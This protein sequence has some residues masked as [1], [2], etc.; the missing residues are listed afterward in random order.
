MGLMMGIRCK[1]DWA[2]KVFDEA[3]T[4]KWREEAQRQ[5]LT[6]IE[7]QYAIDECQWWAKQALKEAQISAVEGVFLADNVVSDDLRL[8]LSSGLKRLEN[9]PNDQKDWHPRSDNQVLDLIHPSLFP[10]VYGRSR[11]VPGDQ[12][13]SYQELMNASE[14]QVIPAPKR[15]HSKW[16]GA[17][18]YF[19]S[20]KFQWLPS[21]V[22][23][24]SE[25]SSTFTS[26]INNLHPARFGDLYNSLAELFD[27]FVPLFNSVLTEGGKPPIVRDNPSMDED[28]L[29][30]EMPDFEDDESAYD[31]WYDNRV[32]AVPPFNDV[33]V[34]F[35]PAKT[36]VDLR[37]RQLQVIVKA[38]NIH[39][40]PEKP[41][42][43]GGAWHVEG[44]KNESIVATGLYYY[45]VENITESE[46]AFRI[47]ECSM[48]TAL[49]TKNH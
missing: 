42:Y 44:M 7:I 6:E 31:D 24:T 49:L 18:D 36:N 47:G 14:C 23:V 43:P 13:L 39:L 45:D 17:V 27:H 41:E 2:T 19:M 10:I 22:Y 5:H 15:G 21:E 25:G 1:P 8:K 30:P 46:L 26:Y 3:I 35:L 37:G 4:T 29:Y 11:F 28:T 16:N 33:F 12:M 32:P 20:E 34:P 40:T 48:C 9:V 38:A